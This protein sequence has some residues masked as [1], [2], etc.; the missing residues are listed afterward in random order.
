MYNVITVPEKPQRPKL[1][2]LF[3]LFALSAPVF[4]AAAWVISLN[5]SYLHSLGQVL[6]ILILTIPLLIIP[7]LLTL[8]FIDNH[9]LNPLN[10][11][12]SVLQSILSKT[13]RPLAN[14]SELQIYQPLY[15]MLVQL[16]NSLTQDSNIF[17]NLNQVKSSQNNLFDASVRDISDPL[18]ILNLKMEITFMNKAAEMF[19]GLVRTNTVGKKIDQAIRFYDK[20]N[21]EITPAKYANV[22]TPGDD[23]KVFSAPEIKIISNI[24][25]QVFADVEILRPVAASTID[26]SCLILLHDRTKEKQLEAMKL[27]FVSMAAHELRTPLTSIKGYIS[28]FINEN[29]TK[30]TPEQM[31]FITRINTS[32]QQLSGLVE[33]LLSVARVERGAMNLHTQVVDWVANVKSQVETFEHR[34]DEKRISL[35]FIEPTVAIPRVSVDLVRI[36]EVL[37]NMVSNAINYTEPMGKIEVWV[38]KKDDMVYTHVRDT[39]KGLSK[40]SIAQ[41]FSK[42]FR[43]QGGP[44]EQASKGNGLGLY[45]SKAIVELHHGQ[46]WAESPGIGKGSTFSFSLPATSDNLDINVLTKTI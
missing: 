23:I 45:L 37:N 41:L 9:Y 6:L 19:T 24:N 46:I 13:F 16:Q 15:L 31:M 30:L 18:I 28:V 32:T 3:A 39:G 42:F 29:K 34:A 4:L 20:N 33:N 36:N 17:G 10:Q 22:K 44:A 12:T 8:K 21:Q 35:K 43:V 27:D 1:I 2:F 40:E 25:V 7:G 11:I 38:D 5:T 14:A 26:I